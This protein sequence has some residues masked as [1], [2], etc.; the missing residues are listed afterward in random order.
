MNHTAI[1]KAL[2]TIGQGFQDLASAIEDDAGTAHADITADAANP[3]DGLDTSGNTDE[4]RR[5]RQAYVLREFERGGGRLNRDQFRVAAQ[6]VGYDNR[7]LAGFSTKSADLIAVERTDE[8]YDTGGRLLTE[9]GKV[10]LA[11]NRHLLPDD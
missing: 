7:G 2:L 4:G 3:W 8:G 9:K 11:A 6:S 1:A 5:R 10:R